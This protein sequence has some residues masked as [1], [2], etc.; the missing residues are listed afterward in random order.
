MKHAR[1]H[2]I[3]TERR[4]AVCGFWLILR[5]HSDM[6]RATHKPRHKR[7]AVPTHYRKSSILKDFETFLVDARVA[8]DD[9]VL[10]DHRFEFAQE[11]TFA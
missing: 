10:L 6:W 4:F 7:R 1:D 3:S 8:L 2:A 11:A 5:A 9:D